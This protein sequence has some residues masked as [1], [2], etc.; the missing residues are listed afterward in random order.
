MKKYFLMAFLLISIAINAQKQSCN[1]IFEGQV[2]DQHENTA[3][4]F[5]KIQIKELNVNILSDSIGRF[6]IAGI[7]AGE[8]TIICLHHIGCE[9]VKFKRDIN[10]NTFEKIFIE[11]HLDELEE[12]QVE[13]TVFKMSTLSV[14]KPSELEKH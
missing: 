6:K 4:P 3:V 8:Y 12:V 1:F 11:F 2:I 10:A 13:Y 9:P 14:D 5:A 7:C